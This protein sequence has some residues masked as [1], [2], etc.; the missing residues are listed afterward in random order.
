MIYGLALLQASAS[1]RVYTQLLTAYTTTA[2]KGSTA[3]QCKTTDTLAAIYFSD[4]TI[5]G[6]SLLIIAV[7][8]KIA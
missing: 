1:P 5:Y 2:L 8:R 4:R 3:F 7:E 6:P